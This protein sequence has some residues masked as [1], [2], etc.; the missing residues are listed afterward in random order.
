LIYYLVA[1]L[2]S[3]SYTKLELIQRDI[4]TKYNLFA[5]YEKLPTLHITLETM[6]GPDL[7][8]L[9][10]SIREVLEN[11]SSFETA[12]NGVICFE[13]PFKSVN[14]S[15]LQGGVIES[16][17]HD[18]NSYLKEK[19][20][21]VRDNLSHYKL[22]VSLAN[23]FFSKKNWTDLEYEDACLFAQISSCNI[24][25]KINELQLWK[26]INDEKDMVV[27]TYFLNNERIDFAQ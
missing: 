27:Y 15:I 5:P 4:C 10:K 8:L 20:F 21:K 2:D 17:S 7:S 1:I 19:G 26:P 9:D 6:D 22:H 12:C 18:L 16:L 24:K 11:Y 23:S 14:L 3:E 13:P 25:I